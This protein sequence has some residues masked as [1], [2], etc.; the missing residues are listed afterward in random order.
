MRRSYYP[1]SAS[2]TRRLWSTTRACFA[3][4]SG[5][6]ATAPAAHGSSGQ[7]P[8]FHP[9]LIRPSRNQSQHICC[10]SRIRSSGEICSPGWPSSPT[11]ITACI[12]AMLYRGGAHVAHSSTG[13]GTEGVSHVFQ[14]GNECV[15]SAHCS[16]V[17]SIQSR[18]RCSGVHARIATEIVVVHVLVSP[19]HPCSP[20]SNSRFGALRKQGAS[21]AIGGLVLLT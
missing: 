11:T 21:I 15:A 3:I 18:L 13:I 4:A 8:R 2:I 19:V 6:N 17:P 7:G 1:F 9:R 20:I 16:V 5:A 12:G 10:A 14:V